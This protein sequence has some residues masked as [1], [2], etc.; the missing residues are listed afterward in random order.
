M[1]N[2]TNVKYNNKNNSVVVKTFGSFDLIEIP[3]LRS[4]YSKR[5]LF[6]SNDMFNVEPS[7]KLEY[8]TRCETDKITIL[9][10]IHN[11]MFDQAV[12]SNLRNSIFQYDLT[13]VY[14]QI[15][16][17]D[18]QFSDEYKVAYLDIENDDDL[19]ADAALSP[20]FILNV[21]LRD[22]IKT[23]DVRNYLNESDM[24]NQFFNWMCDV[25]FPDI[26]LG[27]NVIGFDLK[28]I[29]NRA[30]NLG[31]YINPKF[32]M[33]T[34]IDGMDVIEKM[35][36][37]AIMQK[38]GGMSLE[39]IAMHFLGEGK[40][41]FNGTPGEL[42]RR[43]PDL[44]VE[45]CIKDTNLVKRLDEKLHFVKFL[46]ELQRVSGC[47]L[48]DAF[49]NSIAID[50]LF[51]R[52]YKDFVF[53][54]KP[55]KTLG[56]KYEGGYVKQPPVGIF[57]EVI[58]VDVGSLYPSLILTFNI[59]PDTKCTKE[60]KLRPDINVDGVY[61]TLEKDGFFREAIG[62]LYDERLK[63]KAALHNIEK[64]TDE[65]T[66]TYV[67]QIAFKT[68]LN[69]VYGVCAF[70]GFRFYDVDIAK[71]ITS[72]GRKMIKYVNEN[73]QRNELGIPLYSDTDSSFIKCIMPPKYILHLINDS[74]IPSFVDKH[75]GNVKDN[76]L[77][78]GIDARFTHI[79]FTGKKK[80]YLALKEDGKLYIKGHDMIKY[81]VP[82]LIRKMMEEI[83]YGIFKKDPVDILPYLPKICELSFQDLVVIKKLNKSEGD[84]ATIPQ[85]LTARKWTINHFS[86]YVN[87]EE[88]NGRIVRMLYVSIPG[89]LNHEILKQCVRDNKP[90]LTDDQINKC[91][92]SQL[93]SKISKEDKQLLPF[94]E[95]PP[96]PIIE[97]SE[98][99]ETIPEWVNINYEK[100]F[101][102][103]VIHKMLDLL[104]IPHPRYKENIRKIRRYLFDK[105]LEVLDASQQKRLHKSI[106]KQ[107]RK[108]KTKYPDKM[109]R[110]HENVGYVISKVL[111][112][113]D[114]CE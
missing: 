26:V 112:E 104:F 71:S 34:W 92:D 86:E 84:Y 35:F 67:L 93:I 61:F 58:C 79:I 28:Y 73:V 75:N 21:E 32:H 49:H 63:L 62:F 30:K 45:Y 37:H 6:Q 12:D 17:N 74:I 101:V 95:R 50:T 59:S 41:K 2:V 46:I 76:R 20:I 48:S 106:W 65:Y 10:P 66:N 89:I 97:V 33:I 72:L 114:K 56:A 11:T 47:L 1:N 94:Y 51:L 44:A 5:G 57:D 19:N 31:V 60:N 110:L 54:T 100:Y 14:Q 38:A 81:D 42:W 22:E 39:K 7:E 77:A 53:P 70:A 8:F 4:F 98:E 90:K 105:L 88:L 102:F 82:I 109:E 55:K 16:Y 78:M 96:A 99:V 87:P 27:W 9:D 64:D 107:V 91:T 25:S 108:S 85:H 113:L 43:D 68:I 24:L 52:R 83:L 29:V 23:F 80:K 69:S 103:F 3:V 40:I 18:Y 36:G 15:I 111:K 13:A